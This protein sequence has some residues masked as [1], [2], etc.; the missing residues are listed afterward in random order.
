MAGHVQHTGTGDGPSDE[1]RAAAEWQLWHERRTA[2]VS[3]PYG[4]LALTGTHWLDDHPDG[5]IP[6]LPGRWTAE[7]DAVRLTGADGDGLTLDGAPFTGEARLTADHGPIGEARA[8]HGERRFPVLHR[9]G[10][11]A[12]RDFDPGA[13]A[14]RAFAGIEATAYDARWAL[15]GRYVPYPERTGLR[16]RNADGVER[17]LGLDGEIVFELGGAERTLRVAVEDDGSLWAV[18]SDP[19]GTATGADPDGGNSSY[20]FRFL[21]PR[22]PAADGTVTV[23]FNRALLP[24]CAFADHFICPFPPPGNTLPVPVTAGERRA[25][26]R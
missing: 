16:V 9:E 7:G 26:T 21:R 3:G 14:R 17:G 8:G 5:R 23:D 15:P 13:P 2:V 6:G 20:R 25:T 10:L 24:P 1:A 11:W 4:P 19:T 22:P 18:F 12:V